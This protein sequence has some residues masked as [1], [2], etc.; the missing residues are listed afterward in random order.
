MI[1]RLI[2]R[3]YIKYSQAT[4][5]HQTTSPAGNLLITEE[6]RSATTA[7]GVLPSPDHL[8]SSESNFESGQ[9]GTSAR[10]T[11]TPTDGNYSDEVS[12]PQLRRAMNSLRDSTAD[13]DDDNDRRLGA[14]AFPLEAS[15][16]GGDVRCTAQTDTE[17]GRRCDT[18]R[19]GRE[20]RCTDQTDIE[21]CRQYGASSVGRQSSRRIVHAA[22]PDIHQTG[23]Q[24]NGG[25]WSYV[26]QKAS[27]VQ[28]APG[29][30][31]SVMSNKEVNCV[32]LAPQS[33]HVQYRRQSREAC[34]QQGF[35]AI[36]D[37]MV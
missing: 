37:P 36:A 8:Y 6:Q 33:K 21:V 17:I 10:T 28:L 32:V 35:S 12:D 3:W 24:N 9:T 23:D 5:E 11:S 7:A 20:V 1:L 27:S 18:S 2:G 16:V 14:D 4:D 34:V 30:A 25:G 31:R 29:L 15:R 26:G 13:G 19:V 22:R